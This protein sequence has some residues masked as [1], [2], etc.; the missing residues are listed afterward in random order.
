MKWSERSIPAR[1]RRWPLHPWKAEI[2]TISLLSKLIYEYK[3][4]YRSSPQAQ[5]ILD[6][7]ARGKEEE[8]EKGKY[9]YNFIYAE[10]SS[11]PGA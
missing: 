11:K 6:I 3:N 2:E 8:Q 10:I 7:K 9:I 1:F 5:R 4:I